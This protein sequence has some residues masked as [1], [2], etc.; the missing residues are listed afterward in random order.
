VWTWVAIDSDT[1]LVP[2]YRVGGRDLID[3]RSFIEDL[4]GR[5]RNRVQLTTD[6]NY[7][8]LEAVRQAFKGEIDYAMLVKVYGSDANPKKPRRRDVRPRS[9]LGPV[10][11][12]IHDAEAVALGVGKDHVVGVRWSLVPMHFSSAQCLQPLYL[13]GLI[14]CEQIKVD[15]GRHL[16]CRGNLVKRQ[17]RPDT[18]PWSKQDEVVV[19]VSSLIVESRLPELGLALEIVDAQNN[20]ADAEH[21]RT[22]FVRAS[23]T[24]PLPEQVADAPTRL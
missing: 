18:I 15:A 20:R 14:L 24:D 6:G 16:H 13:V 17:T 2:T 5:L 1:K 10:S 9:A 22:L 8:Y 4:A 12:R 21:R 7:A 11:G 19:H 23:Q 3:A